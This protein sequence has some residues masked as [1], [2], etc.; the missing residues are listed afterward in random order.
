MRSAQQGVRQPGDLRS[1]LNA[2]EAKGQLTRVRG[3]DAHLEIGEITEINNTVESPRALLFEGI[4][5]VEG[6]VLASAA[7][8]AATLSETL[9]FDS[10]DTAS[11][12][13]R[14]RG[15]R[16]SE[17]FELARKQQFDW[18]D[19]G[20]VA[21]HC[22]LGDQVDICRFPAPLWR[23]SDGGRYIGTGCVVITQD[24]Q[25][26]AYNGGAY[27]TMVVDR[28]RAT[29][30]MASESRHGRQHQLKWQKAGKPCPIVIS[31][32][33]DPLFGILAGLE[34]PEGTFELDVA[35]AILGRPCQMLRGRVTGLPVPA[36]A[37]LV[38]EGWLTDEHAPEG[39][40]GEFLGYYAGGERPCPVVRIEAVYHREDPIVLGSPPGKPPHDMSYYWSVMRSALLHDQIQAAGVPGVTAVWADEVGGGRLLI[41]VAIKQRY[42]GHSRQAGLI[43][44]Q[45]QAA[46]YLGR[47]VIVVD[48]DIDPSDLREVMWAVIS[49][50]DPTTDIVTFTNS[51]GSGAD[52][53]KGT[54]APGTMFSS[55]AVIDACRPFQGLDSFPKVAATPREKL[56][57]VRSKWSH[58]WPAR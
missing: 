47:Y 54:Y 38:I 6:R 26:N 14:L 52:P 50:T 34:A 29:I 7:S 22:L 45:C 36:H 10:C 25:T 44:S 46:V 24:P 32:G 1:W 13:T 58:L 33:H 51:L 53:M 19:D 28:R 20:P 8:C 43:A 31:L 39:P 3:A 35:G 16:L 27:R 55:R 42:F 41:T 30:L 18:V 40:F 57:Q 17:W 2:I 12:V 49:R 15:G 23:M 4:P 9:G 11:L 5:G 21:A 56:N 37:E 48:E